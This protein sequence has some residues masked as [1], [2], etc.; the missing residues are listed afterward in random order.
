M[1]GDR[2]ARK[3]LWGTLDGTRPP[4]RP[5]RQLPDVYAACLALMAPELGEAQR[6]GTEG[7]RRYDW[8]DACED[9][10]AWRDLIEMCLAR[11]TTQA[12]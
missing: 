1:E 10:D 2:L 4:G 8:L 11:L 12:G 6:A 3:V 7:V 5:S 9:K